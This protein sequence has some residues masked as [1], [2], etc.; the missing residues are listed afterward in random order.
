[1]DVAVDRE[2]GLVVLYCSRNVEMVIGWWLC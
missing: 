2:D 1:M